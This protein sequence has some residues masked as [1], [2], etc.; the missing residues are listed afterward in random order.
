MWQ[1]DGWAPGDEARRQDKILCVAEHDLKSQMSERR[2]QWSHVEPC[3]AQV[4]TVVAAAAA[5]FLH[6]SFVVSKH[7]A[8]QEVHN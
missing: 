2:L 8:T 7:G 5:A 1:R 3:V 6:N 4:W